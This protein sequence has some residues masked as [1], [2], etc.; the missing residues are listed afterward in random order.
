MTKNYKNMKMAVMSKTEWGED[1][2]DHLE[3]LRHQRGELC[4]ERGGGKA[5]TATSY[6]VYIIIKQLKRQKRLHVLK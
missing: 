3:G 6:T 2:Q 5:F 4:D 1:N